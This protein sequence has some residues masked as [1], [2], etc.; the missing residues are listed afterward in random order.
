M[1]FE[2]TFEVDAPVEEVYD[3]LLDLERVAPAMP[4]AQVT[5][6]VSDDSYKVAI[7]VKLGPMTMNYSGDV[8]IRDKDPDAHRATMHVKAREAR[9]QGTATADVV[10]SLSSRD[11]GGTEGR[12]EA[13]VQLAGRAA[14][15]GRGLIEDVSAKLLQQFADNLGQMLGSEGG[16]AAPGGEGAASVGAAPGGDAAASAEPQ[17]TGE[18]AASADREASR[19]APSPPPRPPAEGDDAIDAG[20]LASGLLRDKLAKPETIGAI[21]VVLLIVVLMRRR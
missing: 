8:E 1:R 2:N 6:K 19:P 13:E 16:G 5:E 11:G 14:A 15:M 17:P 10:Q 4:G 3:A 21:A 18:G 7:K 12:I 20:A 9:G